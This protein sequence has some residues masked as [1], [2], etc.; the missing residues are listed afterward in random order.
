MKNINKSAYVPD[1][2]ASLKSSELDFI[3]KYRVLDKSQKE[4]YRKIIKGMADNELKI[5][6]NETD[7]I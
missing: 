3:L 4:K 6:K 2:P 1:R 5:N 7:K